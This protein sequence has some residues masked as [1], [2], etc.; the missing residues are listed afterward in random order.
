[1]G[2]EA[3]QWVADARQRLMISAPNSATCVAQNGPA[4]IFEISITPTPS[5][6]L[7]PRPFP[8]PFRLSCCRSLMRVPG[9]QAREAMRASV[10]SKRCA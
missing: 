9:P 8:Q 6:G 1:M 2:P 3:A 5:S 10:S 4:M 7:I